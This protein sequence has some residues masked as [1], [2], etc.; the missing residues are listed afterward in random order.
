[1]YHFTNLVKKVSTLYLK[2]LNITPMKMHEAG[3]P[4]KTKMGPSWLVLRLKIILGLRKIKQ[5]NLGRRRV[6]I[7]IK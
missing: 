7:L 6:R 2:H 4:K 5:N 3:T 1:M